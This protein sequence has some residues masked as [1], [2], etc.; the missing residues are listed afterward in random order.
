MKANIEQ[1]S[2][3]ILTLLATPILLSL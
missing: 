1:S 2:V 3:T